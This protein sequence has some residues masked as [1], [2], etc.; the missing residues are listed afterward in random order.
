MRA[1][2]FHGV[3]DIR[4]TD[5]PEPDPGPGEVV[6]ELAA[7]GVCGTDL[8][9]WY[10]ATKAPTVL[11][12]EPVGVICTSVATLIVPLPRRSVACGRPVL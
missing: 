12:H 9:D 3:D 1:A 11:G 2:V 6:V 4:M 10:T 7:C 5:L 8:M